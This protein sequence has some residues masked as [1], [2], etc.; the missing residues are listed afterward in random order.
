MRQAGKSLLT[1]RQVLVVDD[2]DGV[3][4]MLATVLEIAGY[5]V[6]VAS[7]GLDALTQLEEHRP[8]LILLDLMMPRMDGFTFA[9]E[10]RRRGLR[11]AVPII[12]I[13]A[14][15][16]AQQGARTIAADDCVV[17]PFNLDDLLQKVD[18]LSG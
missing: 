15:G 5:K 13:S 12:V 10:L 9:D 7:D 6:A 8:A 4:D 11:P 1:S 17:K 3:R 14:S 16:V 2:D 18:R